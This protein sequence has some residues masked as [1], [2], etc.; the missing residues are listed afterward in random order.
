M[1]LPGVLVFRLAVFITAPVV[2]VY[3]LPRLSLECIHYR[4]TELSEALTSPV[5]LAG[6]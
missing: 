4:A 2:T 1:S 3:S 6:E 5:V